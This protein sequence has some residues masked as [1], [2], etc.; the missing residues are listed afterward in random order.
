M[1]I[2][3]VYIEPTPYILDLIHAL[4]KNHP[5]KIHVMFLNNSITQDW[6]LILNDRHFILEKNTFSAIKTLYK[7][8]FKE[9]YNT[10]FLAGWSHPIMLALLALAKIRRISV[11]V[12]SDTP[13]L[14]HISRW[15]RII[16]RILYPILFLLPNL[17]LPGGTRQANYLRHYCVPSKKII[18][19]KMTVDVLGIQKAIQQYSHNMKIELRKKLAISETDFV[20]LFVGRLIKRKGIAELLEAC[21]KIHYP[22]MKCIII[23][24]GPLKSTVIEATKIHNNIVYAGWLNQEEIIKMYFISDVFVLPAQWEPWGLVIN[25]AMAAGKPVIV[26]DQVGCADDLVMHKK[27]GLIIKSNSVNELI[28]AMH[29]FLD[30]QKQYEAMSHNTLDLISHWTLEDSVKQICMALTISQS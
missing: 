15:K 20:F 8:I 18:L 28:L 27:T 10:I 6:H 24:D 1:K 7:I 11:I 13:L 3:M 9:K 4:E 30:H 25:E 19:E 22:N 23:G 12:D 29:Y 2:L 17:F 16:K 14:P 26:T 21:K 5:L